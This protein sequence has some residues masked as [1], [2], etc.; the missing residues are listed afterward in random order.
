MFSL[1]LAAWS[2]SPSKHAAR[3]AADDGVGIVVGQFAAEGRAARAQTDIS[4][5]PGHG[6]AAREQTDGTGKRDDE[7]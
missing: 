6:G 5:S 3:R 1:P 2:L 7:Q 4:G